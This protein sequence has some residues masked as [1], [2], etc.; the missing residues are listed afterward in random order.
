LHRYLSL[1]WDDF[2]SIIGAPVEQMWIVEHAKYRAQV[3]NGTAIPKD[4]R[5]CLWNVDAQHVR[6]APPSDGVDPTWATT[7]P[8]E[9]H[10][11]TS[12]LEL[13]QRA[14]VM[15]DMSL[16]GMEHMPREAV[17]FDCW[18][19][20]SREDNGS[21]NADF[22]VPKKFKIDPVYRSVNFRASC[23]IVSCKVTRY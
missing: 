5:L 15:Q 20:L 22:P 23:C 3:A 8:L 7:V 14:R 16:Y 6:T 13:F 19:V 9:G 1:P 4:P 2:T 18:P 11:F 12:L 10:N 21:D 17:L